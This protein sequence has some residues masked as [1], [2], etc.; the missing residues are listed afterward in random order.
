[1]AG[2]DDII[3]RLR[4]AVVVIYTAKCACASGQR[5]CVKS[6]C[7]LSWVRL[8]TAHIAVVAGVVGDAAVD[9]VVFADVVVMR[10]VDVYGGCR[11][12]GNM[13]DCDRRLLTCSG[14][15]R[16]LSSLFHPR[17]VVCVSGYDVNNRTKCRANAC[18]TICSDVGSIWLRM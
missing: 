2:V 5:C 7:V 11:H 8:V 12:I 9:A 18:A 3:L 14:G 13:C 1:M 15:Q 4:Y 16:L 17:G 10:R 6:R